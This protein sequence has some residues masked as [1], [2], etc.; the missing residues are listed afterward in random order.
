MRKTAFALGLVLLLLGLFLISQGAQVVSPLAAAL[1]QTSHLKTESVLIAPTLLAVA[2]GNHTWISK[3]LDSNVQ[4]AG[5]F[6]V[7]TGREMDFY[8]MNEN[9]FHDWRLGRPATVILAVFSTGLYKFNLTLGSAG[10]YYFI[11]ENQE[12]IRSTVIF[13]LNV[14]NDVIIV[15]PIVEY[16]PYILTMIGILLLAWGAVSGRKKPHPVKPAEPEEKTTTNPIQSTVAG[17][18]CG[19]CGAENAFG[20]KFCKGPGERP[21]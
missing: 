12:N 19:F 9:S 2:P 5:S 17:W 15:N 7:G 6:Q 13:E 14:V 1:G 20:D 8:V 10:N 21:V 18:K 16:L 11:F 3:H 4:V